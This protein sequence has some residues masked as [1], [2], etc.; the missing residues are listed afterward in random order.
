MTD[1]IAHIAHPPEV[2]AWSNAQH[3]RLLAA[4]RRG[5]AALA[6]A[7]VTEHLNGTVY[8]VSG[9]LP[10]GALDFDPA[11]AVDSRLEER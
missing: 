2:L 9:L 8:V 6:T 10:T 5:D 11:A 4:I 1:V 3:V 7:I